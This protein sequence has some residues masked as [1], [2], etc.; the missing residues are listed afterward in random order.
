MTFRSLVANWIGCP[1]VLGW[2]IHHP[3]NLSRRSR[4]NALLTAN[5]IFDDEDCADLCN[6]DDVFEDTGSHDSPMKEDTETKSQEE[7]TSEVDRHR[8]RLQMNWELKQTQ[9]DCDV[10]DVT[11]CG[12]MC[13]ECMG[14]GVTKC[15]FCMG[16]KYVI[17]PER[18]QKLDCPVCDQSGNEVC[19][20]CRGSGWLAKWTE[21]A[22][23]QP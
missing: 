19:S 22:K 14:S 15:R 18:G 10:D 2:M 8:L 16:S 11:S 23:F 21:L 9:E 7:T 3:M 1:L 17:L 20:Q 4:R 13:N 6:F 12:A 5:N